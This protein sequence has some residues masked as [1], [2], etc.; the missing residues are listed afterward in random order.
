MYDDCRVRKW[1]DA[2]AY[3][4]RPPQYAIGVDGEEDFRPRRTNSYG[5]WGGLRFTL[6]TTDDSPPFPYI[7]PGIIVS[8]RNSVLWF[9][10]TMTN[11]L[12]RT[13]VYWMYFYLFVWG[14]F[15]LEWRGRGLKLTTHHHLA[16]RSGNSEILFSS[17]I[18]LHGMQRENLCWILVLAFIYLLIGLFVYV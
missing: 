12:F 5:A 3:Y 13:C 7:Q 10:K 9:D 15:P 6:T 18:C 2:S 14:R 4:L 16:P 11:C 17:T 1:F 8:N